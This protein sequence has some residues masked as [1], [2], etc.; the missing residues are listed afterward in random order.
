M[1][2]GDARWWNFASLDDG[3]DFEITLHYAF[4]YFHTHLLALS[5]NSLLQVLG[6]NGGCT[7]MLHFM[8]S[9]LGVLARFATAH[10][11]QHRFL[12]SKL[13]NALRRRSL[14]A[15]RENAKGRFEEAAIG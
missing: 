10:G 1:E 14:V 4:L 15:S 11:Q 13:E 7:D 2:A 6:V 9:G 5:Q 3:T 8:Y 12:V